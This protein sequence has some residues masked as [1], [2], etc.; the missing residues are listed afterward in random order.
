MFSIMW[1]QENGCADR[2]Q[3]INSRRRM[4]NKPSPT[5]INPDQHSEPLSWMLWSLSSYR[6]KTL[7]H[8]WLKNPTDCICR[9]REKEKRKCN[10]RRKIWHSG[11]NTRVLTSRGAVSH[12]KCNFADD[13]SVGPGIISDFLLFA[14]AA[15]FLFGLT[16]FL[17]FLQQ[18]HRHA[19]C[20]ECLIPGTVWEGACSI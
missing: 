4:K 7:D 16:L 9:S 13:L 20:F 1:W 10:L 3:W 5:A 15:P 18:R 19:G 8:C 12:G 14:W 6:F 17:C 2:K 11:R